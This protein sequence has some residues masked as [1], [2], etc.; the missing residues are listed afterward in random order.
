MSVAAF[1]AAQRTEHDVPHAVACRALGVSRVLVL[2]VAR[3]AADTPPGPADR[4]GRRGPAASSTPR[5]APTAARGSASSC[6]SRAGGCR[7]TPSPQLMAELGLVARVKRRR[8]GLTRPGKRPAAPDLV[9]RRV[10]R[11]RAGRRLVR[12]HDRDRHRRGQ[13]LPRHRH[14]PVLPPDARLRHGRPPRRR[15]GRRGVAHGRGHPRRRRRRRDLPQRP[16]QRIHLAPTSPGPAPAGGA[17]VD[18]PGRVRASTTPSPR[19]SSPPS[20]SSTSTAAT[21]APEPRPASRSPP[22]SPTSTTSAAGTPSATGAHPSTTNDQRH[23]PWRLK[24]HNGALHD[25]RGLTG[26]RQSRGVPG[27]MWLV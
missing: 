15:P 1:I 5:A 10:H 23:E 18:G 13:A 2:Q 8:R 9:E 17:P 20:R 14:R 4:A 26:P 7:T 24:P 25:S 6:V 11:A 3:P 12:R 19:P 22:G 21:S 16:R 27:L